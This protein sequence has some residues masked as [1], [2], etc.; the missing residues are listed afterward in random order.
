MDLETAEIERQNAI[1][2]LIEERK[3][4]QN[5]KVDMDARAV[6]K[7]MTEYRDKITNGR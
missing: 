1:M 3:S 5:P 7:R 6:S 4:S 2:K